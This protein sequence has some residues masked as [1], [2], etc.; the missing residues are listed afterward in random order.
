LGVEQGDL[1]DLL[2]V[3]ANRVCRGSEFRVLTSLSECFGLFLVPDEIRIGRRLGLFLLGGSLDVGDLLGFAGLLVLGDGG[4][5]DVHFDTVQVRESRFLGI[6]ALVGRFTRRC[7]GGRRLLAR[8]LLVV[9]LGCLGAATGAGLGRAA[10][11][12]AFF[13]GRLLS[14]GLGL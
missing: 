5:N 7:L 13:R 1:A 8:R 6:G 12:G 4:V 2:E 11:H 3:G 10:P 9:G 14:G